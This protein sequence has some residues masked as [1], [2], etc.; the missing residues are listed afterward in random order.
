MFIVHSLGGLVVKAALN[1]SAIQSAQDLRA[2]VEST[3]AAIFFGTPHRGSDMAQFGETVAK[4]ASILTGKPYNGNIVRNLGR[5]NEILSNLRNDF[6]K[7]ALQIMIERNHFESSTFQENKGYSSL[8]GFQGK[9]VEDDA[10]EMGSHDRSDHINRNHMDMIRFYGPEDPEYE[11]VLGEVSRHIR[12]I[13]NRLDSERKRDPALERLRDENIPERTDGTL[14]WI[15]SAA[16]KIRNEDPSS[17]NTS[18]TASQLDLATW[19]KNGTGMYWITGKPGSGKSTSMKH[20]FT[21]PQTQDLLEFHETETINSNHGPR[22]IS[23]QHGLR[24]RLNKGVDPADWTIVGIFATNRG[25]EDQKLWRPLLLGAI[26]QLLEHKPILIP[27]VMDLSHGSKHGAPANRARRFGDITDAE[28][29]FTTDDLEEILFH[30]KAQLRSPC[31]VLILLDGLD[32]LENEDDMERCIKL[33][34]R[35]C[36]TCDDSGNIF[37]A[38]LSGRSESTLIR[39]LSDIPF[40]EIHEHTYHDIRKHVESRLGQE[41]QILKGADTYDIKQL[42]NVIDYISMNSRGVFLWA[43][44]ICNLIVGSLHN[45]ESLSVVYEHLTRLPKEVAEL[46]TYTLRRISPHLR[47]KAY[48]MLETVL[49][50]REPLTLLQLSLVV[51]VAERT[52]KGKTDAWY[53]GGS[54]NYPGSSHFLDPIRL[55]TILVSSC[56]CML[57]VSSSDSDDDY[58]IPR[59]QATNSRSEELALMENAQYPQVDPACTTVKLVHRS[60]RDFLLEPGCLDVLLE[61]IPTSGSSNT[62]S[63]PLNGHAYLLYFA[64]AW[65]RLPQNL[66]SQLRCKFDVIREVAYNAALIEATLGTDAKTLFTVL[67]DLDREL[68]IHHRY[69]ECWPLEWYISVTWSHGISSWNFTF[70]AF[71]VAKDMRGY[72]QHLVDIATQRNDKDYFLN[73]KDGRPL[74]FF[75]AFMPRETPKPRMLEFLLQQ[76]ADVHARFEG[77]TIIESIV[78]F[79]ESTDS[80]QE[81]D[82]IKLLLNY[83]ADV[84][85]RYLKYAGLQALFWPLLHTVAHFTN[86]ELHRRLDLMEFLQSKGANLN[87]VDCFGQT[88]VEVLYWHRVEIPS[89]H[90]DWLFRKGARITKRMISRRYFE[91][92]D[93]RQVSTPQRIEESHKVVNIRSTMHSNMH[94]DSYD[95][96]SDYWSDDEEYD[97]PGYYNGPLIYPTVPRSWSQDE[98]NDLAQAQ[99]WLIQRQAE[100]FDLKGICDGSGDHNAR[101]ILVQKK[102]RRRE[103]YT[104]DAAEAAETC[105]PGWFSRIR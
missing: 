16:A 79:V 93:T 27:G 26:Y 32:E 72:M 62:M 58:F 53:D 81:I 34:R 90:W 40:I 18:L 78:I 102:Y 100:R 15:F 20:L 95:G 17:D 59:R 104:E 88:F 89:P 45:G 8:P 33:L 21:N 56:K 11:M 101:R 50:T 83:G 23:T 36:G 76:G 13:E 31:R 75:A 57:E 48:I 46:Y 5:N 103:W 67:D 39:L 70:P 9:I 19:L 2:V 71:A 30:C 49:R 97:F 65:L 4:A 64:R 22:N 94:Y 85:S 7:L 86:T 99:K 66:K 63:R 10:C 44:S 54:P 92:E 52:I 47:L 3:F 37:K 35:L 28:F 87:A 69:Q 82:V 24:K 74:H 68:T 51:H 12:R 25:S 60:A 77:K 41:S 91:N 73:Q 55:E 6:E 38:C 61:G 14:K 84:N 1:Q 80:A 43:R 98:E 42:S 105:M 29:Q 96:D